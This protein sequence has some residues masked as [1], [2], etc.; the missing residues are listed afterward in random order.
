MTIVAV[1]NDFNL[2][3]ANKTATVC[4][5]QLASVIPCVLRGNC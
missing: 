3:V 2:P 1:G 4:A 5:N